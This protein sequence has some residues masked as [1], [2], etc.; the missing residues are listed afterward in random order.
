MEASLRTGLAH[1]IRE[2]ADWTLSKFLQKI[3]EEF[4]RSVR[5]GD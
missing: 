1:G 4:G 3:R 5:S 2:I